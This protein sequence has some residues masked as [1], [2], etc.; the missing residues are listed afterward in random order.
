MTDGIDTVRMIID[1][2]VNCDKTQITGITKAREII[3]NLGKF[4]MMNTGVLV[5]KL[6]L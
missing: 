5:M 2:T 3:G 4:P 1:P 6:E